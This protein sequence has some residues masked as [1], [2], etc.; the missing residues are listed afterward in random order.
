MFLFY[1]NDKGLVQKGLEFLF[2]DVSTDDA[3]VGMVGVAVE[4]AVMDGM[5]VPG[6]KRE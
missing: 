1:Q 3:V 4:I 5:V 2:E 6:S